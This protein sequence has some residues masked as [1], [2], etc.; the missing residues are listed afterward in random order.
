MTPFRVAYVP[1]VTVSKWARVWADRHPD[2]PL[3]LVGTAESTAL[4]TLGSVDMLFV[5]LPVDDPRI[6]VIPLYVERSVVVAARGHLV[7]AADEVTLADLA[8]ENLLDGPP[9]DA[10]ALAAANAGIAIM[11][12]SLARLH[13]RKDVVSRPVVDGPE[14]RVALVWMQDA[15]TDR[16]D[17]FIGIV[18]GR[19]TRSSRGEPTPPT[20]VAPRR[21][22][23][24]KAVP[25]RQPRKRRQSR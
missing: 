1:G 3:E 19:T 24:K 23:E 8:G 13:A 14:T 15:T 10:V 9:E 20:T 4:T 2:V 25:Q 21:P 17:D 18:R 7:E 12:Q 5:R 6:A 16:I 11:P 22:V